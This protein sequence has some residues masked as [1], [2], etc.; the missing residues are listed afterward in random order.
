MN[1][2]EFTAAS[3][4]AAVGNA[5]FASNAQEKVFQIGLLANSIPLADLGPPM[6]TVNPAPRIIEDGLRQLGW[7]DG[8]N[9]RLIWKTAAGRYERWPDLI[10]EFL[11]MRVDVLVVFADEPAQIALKKTRTTPIVLAGMGTLLNP[12]VIDSMQ[13]PGVNVTGMSIDG[14][15]LGPKRLEM[16]KAAIP[17]LSRVAVLVH[18]MRA[19]VPT[20]RQDFINPET[21]LAASK[22]GVSMFALEFEDIADIPRAFSEIVSKAA[23]G[24]I[25][26]ETPHMYYRE[27]QLPI[28][29]LCIRHRL[30]AMWRI[31]NSVDSGALMAYA[32]DILEFYRS[33]PRYIDKILRGGKAADIP[34][35][36]P[37]KFEF[38]INLK[39][40]RAIGITIP[41]FVLSVADR[42]IE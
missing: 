2:R 15:D 38:L 37:S 4:A 6:R 8:R 30:P 36:T 26:G 23:N 24:L 1:R 21:Q 19:P 27:W 22:L 33:A 40:A 18:A 32:P 39:T 20:Y 3:I 5:P 9:V 10:D 7:V 14:L 12:K 28:H 31:L 42:V 13:R 25:V 17:P 34:I 16:L 11:R 35:E 29:E 41:S